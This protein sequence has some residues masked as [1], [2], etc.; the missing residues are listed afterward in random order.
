MNTKFYHNIGKYLEKKNFY[1]LTYL[2][3]LLKLKK[4]YIQKYIINN[5]IQHN[6]KTI[7]YKIKTKII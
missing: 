7:K 2:Y 5:K 3:L 4:M 1:Q 6:L